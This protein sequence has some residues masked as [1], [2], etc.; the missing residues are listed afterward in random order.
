M[1]S[2]KSVFIGFVGVVLGIGLPAVGQSADIIPVEVSKTQSQSVLGSTVVPY[3]EVTLTAQIP[4]IVKRVAGGVGSSFAAGNTLV[5]IDDSQLQAKRNAVAAQIGTAQSGVTNAQAQYN[6]EQI[7]PRSKD[8]GA[9]PGFGMPAIFDR[10]G[11]RQFAETFMGGYDEQTIR[12]ADLE[13][14]RSA[15]LQAQGG[16]QQ[17]NAQLQELDS[18]ISNATSTA[19]FEGMILSKQ[20]EVGDTVQPGQPLLT[21]GYVKNKRLE[22]DV[23]SGL[24]AG[25]KVGMVVEAR[26]NNSLNTTAK[27]AE[28]YPLADPTRHTVTVKFDLPVGI[29]ATPG[30]YAEVHLPEGQSGTSIFIPKTA[31]FKGGTLPSVLVVKDGKSELRMVRLGTDQSGEKLEVVSGLDAN[32]HI[33]NDPPVGVVS[34]WIPPAK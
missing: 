27:I 17:A 15:V 13:N 24:V 32:E 16:L 7:S 30:N 1:D 3:K 31:L 29:E 9:M 33:I 25:L 28:I 20:V 19:P 23:P 18:A 11:T 14:S 2:K 21:Y 5:Q 6:R 8:I 34:G 22:S 12:Q 10:L 26:I 4:G